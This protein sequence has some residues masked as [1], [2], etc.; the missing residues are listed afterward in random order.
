MAGTL[1]PSHTELITFWN[2]EILVTACLMFGS[3]GIIILL[4]INIKT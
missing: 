2:L 4:L 3:M 1:Q